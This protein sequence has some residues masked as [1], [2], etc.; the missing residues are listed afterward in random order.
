M[1]ILVLGQI[2]MLGENNTVADPKKINIPTMKH[3][4]GSIMLWE[5]ISLIR[6]GVLVS[7]PMHIAKARL[8]TKAECIRMA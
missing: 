7:H 8:W 6:T 3:V 1:N 2:V 5:S 4:N